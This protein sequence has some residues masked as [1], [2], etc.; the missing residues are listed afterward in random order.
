MT[1]TDMAKEYLAAA[2]Q[3]KALEAQ[4]KA[5]KQ[6]RDD[7][8]AALVDAM[9]DEEL[10]S[11]KVQGRLLS[12]RQQMHVTPDMTKEEQLF[13]ALEAHG[14]GSIIKRTINRNTLTATV[15]EQMEINGDELPAWLDG[16]VNIFEQP[17]IGIRKG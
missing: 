13:G 3:A 2:D 11:L 8:E 4:A 10:Q 5:A 6:E 14:L 7:L 9:L 15:K 12:L 1:I 16:V 17:K